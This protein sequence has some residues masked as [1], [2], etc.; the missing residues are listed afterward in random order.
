MFYSPTINTSDNV[1]LLVRL[2]VEIFGGSGSTLMAAVSLLVRLW[3]EIPKPWVGLKPYPRQPPC[4]A[5]SWNDKRLS[6][7]LRFLRQPPCEAVSWNIYF[8]HLL[9]LLSSQPPCEAVS[10]NMTQGQIS[11]DNTVS[12]LVRLWVEIKAKAVTKY[13]YLVSLLV[14]LWV[15]MQPDLWYRS[16][17]LVSLLV[18]LWVEMVR[19]LVTVGGVQGQPPCEAVSW[20]FRYANRTVLATT[21]ASLWGC[22]LKYHWYFLS[23]DPIRQPPCEAV[24]WNSMAC[25]YSIGCSVSLLVRLWVEMNDAIITPPISCVSLLVRL[26]VEIQLLLLS[27]PLPVRQPPWVLRCLFGYAIIDTIL[28]SLFERLWIEKRNTLWL[29][30][31]REN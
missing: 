11:E 15:E 25:M 7:R 24:S 30:Y 21:S 12:L 14:R 18:R 1:S 23:L 16:A 5:V 26:W 31:L 22:E 6:E 3:V 8:R 27:N 4:E 17:V 29:L 13:P 2:W 20:N 19:R 9:S 28:V 10:W